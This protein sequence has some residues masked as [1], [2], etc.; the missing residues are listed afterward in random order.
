MNRI[1]P[2]T[3]TTAASLLSKLEMH[4]GM[5]FAGKP[6]EWTFSRMLPGTEEYAKTG[7]R[8]QIQRGPFGL[9]IGSRFL[10]PVVIAASRLY[11]IPEAETLDVICV[12]FGDQT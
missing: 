9:R 1:H 10:V 12:V 8:W 11:V 7:W 6:R 3:R 2:K 4:C 5:R